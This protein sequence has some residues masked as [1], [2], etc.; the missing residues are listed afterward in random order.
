[1]GCCCTWPL[2][3]ALWLIGF[4]SS[5][6]YVGDSDSSDDSP[7]PRFRDLAQPKSRFTRTYSL[8]EKKPVC[9]TEEED[10]EGLE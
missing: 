7:V 4:Y 2:S 9:Y 5:K 1:M 8:R 6:K 10:E 3:V